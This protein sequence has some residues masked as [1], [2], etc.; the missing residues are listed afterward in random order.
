M[1]DA[2]GSHGASP[3]GRTAPGTD[4]AER[5]RVVPESTGAEAAGRR[6]VVVVNYGSHDLVERNLSSTLTGLPDVLGV[7]VDNRT[8]E[9]ES[10]A[11]SDVGRRHGWVVVPS[12]INVGFGA[13]VA[14]GVAAAR[15]AGATEFLILNPDAHLDPAA[16]VKLL[17]RV[18]EK[19]MELVAPLVV[20]P[21]GTSFAELQDLYLADGRMRASRVRPA[22]IPEA[23]VVRWVSGA[24]FAI[25]SRLWD[26][27]GGF[28]HDYFLYW[29]DVDLCWRVWAAGGVVR[30]D[31]GLTAVHDEGATHASGGPVGAKSPIYYY[32]NIRNRLIFARK[33]LDRVSIR[34]WRRG[35]PRMALLVLLQGGRRQFRSPRRT[36][37]PALRAVR[38]GLRGTTGVPRKGGATPKSIH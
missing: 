30:V 20:R 15:A 32:F 26:A 2:Q 24:C 37:A 3:G 5:S 7:V 29:E 35:A 6:A 9:A 13:G 33:H 12:P 19:P 31:E 28:D 17:A 10:E 27:S 1:E 25:S 38:D 18:R 34:R 14:L 8:S 16:V 4:G 36:I 23:D 11:M 21:D 22:F